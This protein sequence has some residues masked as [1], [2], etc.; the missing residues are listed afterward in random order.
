MIALRAPHPRDIRN[1]KQAPRQS[2]YEKRLEQRHRDRDIRA[3]AATRLPQGN[4]Q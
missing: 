3:V 1:Y 4:K 2:K